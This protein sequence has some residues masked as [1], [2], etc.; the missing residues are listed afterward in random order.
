MPDQAPDKIQ[1]GEGLLHIGIIFMTVVMKRYGFSIIAVNPGKSDRGSAQVTADIFDYSIGV[2]F[3]WLCINI[4]PMFIVPVT[5]CFGLFKRRTDAHLQFVEQGSAESIAQIRIVK[6]GN[7]L[8]EA[9]VGKAAFGDKAVDVRI[10]LEVASKGMQDHDKAGSVVFRTVHLVEERKDD[11]GDG[12][13]EAV[14]ERAVLKEKRAQK[15]IDGEDTVA[16]ADT[17]ELEGHTGSA[18]HGVL[19]AAGGAEAALAVEGDKF[20]FSAGRAAVHG[21]AKSGI[22][23]AEHLIDIF[24]LAVPGMEDVLDL[25]VMV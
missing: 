25:F 4:K 12:V 21:A 17:D 24:D 19:R 7:I 15:F 20:E 9:V 2:T 3:F 23:A 22:T 1:D 11:A 14:K 6:M 16:V 13:K 8:P 10:P 5:E 18:F